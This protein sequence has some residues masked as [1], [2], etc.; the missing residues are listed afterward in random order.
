MMSRLMGFGCGIA[1]ILLVGSFAAASVLEV[2]SGYPTIQLAIEAA[3]SG[4]T[5]QV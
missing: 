3:S 2:P 4:D 1:V 5:V